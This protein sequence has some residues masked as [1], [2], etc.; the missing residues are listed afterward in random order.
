MKI[1][2]FAL[3]ASYSHTSLA[4]RCLRAA[5]ERNGFSDVVIAE[6]NLRDRRDDIL[7]ALY[8]ERADVYGFS[9]YIWNIT[10][11]RSLAADLKALLP[12]TVTVFGGPEVSFETERFGSDDCIDHIITGEGEDALPALCHALRD[13]IP[14]PR[15]LAGGTPDVMRDEG[16]LYRAEELRCGD[17]VYYESSRGCPFRC[18]YCLSS[19][20]GPVR[21]KSVEQTLADLSAIAAMQ[22]KIR[23]VKFVDRTFNYDV[24]RANRIWEALTSDRFPGQY[25]FEICA[26]PALL[27]EES[28]A[29]L[30]RM[31]KGKIR[32]EIGLQSTNPETLAAVSRHID[33][34][35]VLTVCRRLRDMGN[36]QIHLDLIAGLPY[37]TYERFQTSF[38]DAYFCADEL[39]LGFLKLLPGTVL[40][41]RAAEYG[42]VSMADPPYTVLETR[43][44]S[45][46]AFYR[47]SCISD[48]LERYH[49]S[50]AFPRSLDFAVRR[51][52][53][54]FAFFDGLLT[55]L[56]ARD[57]RPIRALSQADAFRYF[58]GYAK[59]Y[60]SPEDADTF[61]GLC[62]LDYSARETRRPPQTVPKEVSCR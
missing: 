6:R 9:A 48:L 27:N 36:L 5:L 54:P 57:S 11:L 49:D 43:W 15:I 39:Q 53:S 13:G 8:R 46:D 62:K 7:Q 58:S 1:V 16:I 32:L 17:L 4:V 19:V 55:Y 38:C 26:S 41:K 37:E 21:A 35:A 28:Y 59:T 30:A 29:I 22:D 44:I 40:R 60:L 31:P 2:L 10:E 61:D 34:G 33:P 18:A 50:G 56:S 3:N 24:S 42:F 14:V 45:R 25:H 23:T 47:L 52:A 12:H 20:C 51:A